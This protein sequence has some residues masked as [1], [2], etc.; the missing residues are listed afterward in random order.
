[1]DDRME[2]I[3]RF[4]LIFLLTFTSACFRV[5]PFYMDVTDMAE[6]AD[7]AAGADLA[8]A[9]A[10]ADLGVQDQPA[11][12]DASSPCTVVSERFDVDPSTRWT[13]LGDA[14]YDTT[15]QRLQLTS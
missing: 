15:N 3:R 14:S 13:L 11:A 2:R 1:M 12:I 6:S 8:M 9:G 7:P 5:N 4:G 10:T